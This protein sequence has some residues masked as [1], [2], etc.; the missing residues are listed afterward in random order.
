MSLLDQ[1]SLRFI[2]R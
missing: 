2:W 1:F